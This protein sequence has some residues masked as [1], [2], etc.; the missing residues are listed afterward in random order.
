MNTGQLRKDLYYRLRVVPI[1]VPPLRERVEDVELLARSLLR[2]IGAEAGRELFLSPDALQ[3]LTAQDW[4]GNVREF[5]NTLR[6]A[7]AMC[8]GQTIGIE[9]LSE[10]PRQKMPVANDTKEDEPS[11]IR[12]A[13]DDHQWRRRQS[14]E[15]T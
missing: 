3:Q 12:A 13:L 4:P 14:G 6:Y 15:T 5:E 11:R 8:E 2:R 1:H 9:H 7:T 10:R